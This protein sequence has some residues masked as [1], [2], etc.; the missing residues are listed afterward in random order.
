MAIRKIRGKGFT[1]IELLVVISV[2]ALLL[3]ILMP[4]LSKVKEQTKQTVCM[5]NMRQIGFGF[6]LHGQDNEGY[7]LPDYRH[8]GMPWD[9]SLGPYLATR[10]HDACKKTFVCP[11]DKHLRKFDPL[12][13][14]FNEDDQFLAR[15]YAINAGL[16]NRADLS[17]IPGMEGNSS[18]IPAKY[19]EVIGPSRVIHLMEFHLGCEDI[20]CTSTTSSYAKVGNV[21]G[22]AAYQEWLTPSVD[23]ERGHMHIKSGNWLFVDAHVD[24]Y[25]ILP[26]ATDLSPQP[27]EPLI[28]PRNWL[29]R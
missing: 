5:S 6:S 18:Y 16:A 10:T 12:G 27:Y 8:N 11:S 2:I 23:V 26:G 17:Y 24:R 9:A 20:L 13:N 4:S 3:S 7:T 14:K 19:Q 29:Y 25:R 1:L 28:F 15:S 21:Q 22:G